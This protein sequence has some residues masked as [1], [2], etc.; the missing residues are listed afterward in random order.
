EDHLACRNR[1]SHDRRLLLK[2]VTNLNSPH[3]ASSSWCSRHLEPGAKPAKRPPR[4]SPRRGG[5][6]ILK[7][8]LL[9]SNSVSTRDFPV[10]SGSN[11]A[12]ASGGQ[13]QP[14]RDP[15]S[16]CRIQRGHHETSF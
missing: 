1:T 11:L 14:K 16:H 3:T 5:R 12:D 7:T 2:R 4:N 10:P 6:P 13:P 15:A 8:R 9:G